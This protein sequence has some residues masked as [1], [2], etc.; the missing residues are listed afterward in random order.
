VFARAAQRFSIMGDH[1][2]A[3]RFAVEA[4][5]ASEAL[6]WSEGISDALASLGVERV[7]TGDRG[8]VDDLVRGVE[9]A[10][11][12]G[13]AAVLARAHNSMAV[14][15]QVL[16]ELDRGF[17]ARLA[18]AAAADRIGS[19]SLTRWFQGVLVDHR[20]RHGDWDEAQRVADDLLAPIEAGS[21]HVIGWQVFT[22][23]AELRA[24]KGDA[25]GAIAD[26][27]AALAAGRVN[28]EPQAV[29]FVL[30]GG[31]HVLQVAGEPDRAAE[32]ARDL[33]G[34]LRDGAEMQFAVI[35]LPLFASAAERLGLGGELVAVLEGQP[36]TPW[37]EAVRAY[38]GGDFA[39]A[40]GILQRTGSRPAEAEARLRAAQQL[41]AEGRHAEAE[42]QLQQALDFYRRVDATLCV[43]ECEALLAA[44]E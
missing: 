30:A 35:N 24:A 2:R 42:E 44:S 36:P 31:A 34:R 39:G 40:A 19:E 11:A 29:C 6:G 23:R 20:Y 1:E 22:I 15:C 27:E 33:L 12:S 18:G 16:G 4:H 32:V 13:S 26:A 37:I 38:V 5:A 10:E 7:F 28:G 17:E 21:P 3:G 25:D 9:F 8:G 43:R 41:A 14:A